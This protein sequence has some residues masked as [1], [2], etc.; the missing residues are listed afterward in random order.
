M[1]ITVDDLTGLNGTRISDMPLIESMAQAELL[2]EQSRQGT[3]SVA[4]TRHSQ[5]GHTT[6]R[7]GRMMMTTP[8]MNRI[9]E[10]VPTPGQPW[11]ALVEVEAGATWSQLHRVL[12]PHG[13]AP[14]VQQS[15]AGFSIGGS[16]SVN[17]HGRDPRWGPLCDS[18]ES[19]VVHTPAKGELLASRTQQPGLFWA[20]LGGY[21][22]C[23]LIKKATLRVIDNRYLAYVGDTSARSI[24]DYVVRAK[25]LLA[26]PD[27]D[28][29]LHY[30]WLSCV[31]LASRFYRSVLITDFKD[32]TPQPPPG[33]PRRHVQPFFLE[34]D[35]GKDELLRA[36]WSTAR[37]QPLPCREL[38]WR[39]LAKRHESNAQH[40]G[41]GERLSRIDW[42]RSATSFTNYRAN[43]T[44][45]IL[46]EYFVPLDAL[47]DMLEAMARLLTSQKAKG[48]VDALSTTLRLVRQDAHTVL[49]YCSKGP[50]LCIAV[51]MAVSV[52]KDAQGLASISPFALHVLSELID[53]AL[54]RQGSFYLPYYK[55]ATQDQFE[56]AYPGYQ[57][58]QTAIETF[59]P[60]SPNGRHMFWNDFLGRYF[61]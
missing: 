34:Q 24:S 30:G 26:N 55:V 57:A 54:A 61:H 13:F 8:G 7:D 48:H 17:C 58:L 28:I 9:G 39:Q 2:I 16:I 20:T 53:L 3:T 33:M 36:G 47:E 27:E 18:V 22:A 60:S 29:H 44:A 5:G 40:E 11:S 14:M 23:G 1:S 46:Q 42:L 49:S 6:V 38:M 32:V 4:G 41:Q 35:W 31:P 15:S 59:N 56:K 51:D 19:I 21:G 52:T 37:E 25:S 45:D 43:K 12:G 50:M 10:L